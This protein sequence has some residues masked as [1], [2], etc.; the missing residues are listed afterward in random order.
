MGDISVGL[1]QEFKKHRVRTMI[2]E[3]ETLKR[4]KYESIDLTQGMAK[5]IVRE[6]DVCGKLDEVRFNTKCFIH[7]Q[8][9]AYQTEEFREH[10]RAQ[11]RK[12]KGRKLSPEHIAVLAKANT[13]RVDTPETTERRRNAQLGKT[14][15]E[16]AKEK[17]RK[18]KF[19]YIPWNKGVPMTEEY[20][21][22]YLAARPRG[23]MS[24]E[25]RE[26]I[27]QGHKGKHV[28]EENIMFGMTGEKSPQWRGG[29]SYLPY[30]EKFD[31]EF[32][33]SVREKFDRTCFLCPTTEEQNGRKLAVHHVNYD[34]NCL[35]NDVQCEFVPLCLKCHG[36]TGSNRG[37][38]EALIMDKL[39]GIVTNRSLKAVE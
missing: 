35:C 16:E 18:A 29:I 38:W 2:N 15:T 24:D 3:K 4:F 28:G 9:C 36:K 17:M 14:H 6:C 23:P 25:H 30:C 13:G 37:Y 34:K 33:E 39:G 32:K 10:G 26:A 31:D 8:K 20:K 11:G 21:A 5:H 1:Q 19:G 22:N 7:C 27:R 12:S